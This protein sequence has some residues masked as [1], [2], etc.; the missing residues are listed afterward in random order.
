MKWSLYQILMILFIVVS[1]WLLE[2]TSENRTAQST[3]GEWTTV[4]SSYGTFFIVALVVTFIYFIFL[5]EAK[6][7][8][9]VLRYPF[10]ENMPKITVAVG[11]L[12]VILFIV[13]GTMGPIM[14]WVEQWRSLLY[15][16]FVYFLFL[17]FLFIFSLE[18]KKER[19]SQQNQKSIHI[20]YV[21]TLL[22]FFAI[23]FLF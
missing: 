18:H 16:F 10:W 1:M 7:D 20:S 11:I 23:Y 8:K 19:A 12:S 22:A 5:I 3:S 6:K 2:Y 4:I 9:S 14:T 21:W 17:I 13:G 15:V